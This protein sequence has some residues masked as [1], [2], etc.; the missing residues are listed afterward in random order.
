MDELEIGMQLVVI[1]ES[2]N[3]L[4]L[5][6]EPTRNAETTDGNNNVILFMP[7]DSLVVLE[8]VEARINDGHSWYNVRYVQDEI[9]KTGWV[10]GECLQQFLI[11]VTGDPEFPATNI[12][13]NGN[14]QFGGQSV[15]LLN[16]PPKVLGSVGLVTFNIG[17]ANFATTKALWNVA[18]NNDKFRL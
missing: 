1:S 8:S 2:S 5:R 14:V 15:P 4:E 11:P 16:Y 10:I 13:Y 18:A 9:E 12:Q 7:P 6:R 3:G 17:T